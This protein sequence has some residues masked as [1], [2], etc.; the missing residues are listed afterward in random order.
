MRGPTARSRNP[1]IST[2]F[3]G[4]RQCARR[5]NAPSYG[6]RRGL[7][8]KPATQAARCE[9]LWPPRSAPVPGRAFSRACP[10][11]SR[12][13]AV[14][15]RRVRRP[16]WRV[17][18]GGRTGRSARASCRVGGGDAPEGPASRA[19]DGE[20]GRRGPLKRM[21]LARNPP[22]PGRLTTRAQAAANAPKGADVAGRG[23]GGSRFDGPG[24]QGLRRR[25]G[26]RPGPR[27]RRCPARANRFQARKSC[28][29]SGQG[30]LSWPGARRCRTGGAPCPGSGGPMLRQTPCPVFPPAFVDAL[31]PSR[32]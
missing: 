3:W 30:A 6:V 16:A 29:A 26:Q 25:G 11:R 14:P 2:R 10:K 9:T 18:W 32:R 1:G 8:M 12:C 23:C 28:T 7:H 27:C 19:R 20:A 22:C 31:R 21:T 4:E 17:S 15:V 13:R 5:W 24:G